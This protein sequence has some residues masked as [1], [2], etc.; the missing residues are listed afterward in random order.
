MRFG[1]WTK[2]LQRTDDVESTMA[3][4]LSYENG[5]H[6]GTP[7]DRKDERIPPM[8]RVGMVLP[9]LSYPPRHHFITVSC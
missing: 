2:E 1:F 6:G 7:E 8:G 5:H 3:R 4:Q 9:S